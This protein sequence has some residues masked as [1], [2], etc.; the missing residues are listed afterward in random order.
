M[1]LSISEGYK[2]LDIPSAGK[3]CR[4]WYRVYGSLSSG[5]RPLV[6]LHGGPGCTHDYLTDLT[7][8]T[9]K[10]NIPLVL[11]DQLGSGN[12]TRLP[13]KAGDTTFWTEDLFLSELHALLVHLGIQNDHDL[14]GHSW[15]GMLASR[16]ASKQPKGLHRLIICSSPCSMGLWVEAASKLREQLPKEIQE[17]LTKHE[18]EGTT[19]SDGYK[20]AVE[21]FYNHFLCTKKPW[22]DNLKRTMGLLEQDPTVYLTMYV[23]FLSFSV[24]NAVFDVFDGRNGPSEFFVT[25][26]LKTWSMVEDAHRINVPTLLTNGRMDEAQDS[27]VFPFFD[28]IPKVKWVT[29]ENSSHTPHIE[30]TERFLK[31]VADFSTL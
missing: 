22:P 25:G 5:K 13:E 23:G 1:S 28:G 21:V 3:P 12:S 19:D 9:S 30:E 24:E 29:F 15:G 26:S 8:L 17:A 20:E 31:V 11:Y 2:E 6:A 16:H 7:A 4:T 18:T 14:L 27:T 10:Y